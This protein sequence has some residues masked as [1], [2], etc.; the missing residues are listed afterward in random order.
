MIKLTKILASIESV[1]HPPVVSL[2]TGRNFAPRR[3]N[4][5]TKTNRIK[6]KKTVN[7]RPLFEQVKLI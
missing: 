5:N 1:T 6:K 4:L 2:H 7:L 3:S